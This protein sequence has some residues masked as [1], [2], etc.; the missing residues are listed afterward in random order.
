MNTTSLPSTAAADA[1][2]GRHTAG[3]LTRA[4]LAVNAAFARIPESLILLLGRVSIALTFWLSGQTKIEGFVLDPI[5]LTAQIGI[6]RLSDNA[7]E[8]FRSEYALPLLSPEFAALSAATA[9]HVFPLLLVLGLATRLSATALLVMTLVIQVFVYPGAYPTHGLWMAVML[10]LM[11]KGAGA[12][13]V[14]GF[15][16]RRRS[17]LAIGTG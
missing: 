5:G 17:A 14:D 2:R 9:E 6:P 15:I 3:P 7:V 8:L 12:L 10:L 13:S 4:I 1:R 16:A 11:A